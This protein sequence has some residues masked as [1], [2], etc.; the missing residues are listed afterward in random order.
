M[1]KYD[2][3]LDGIIN[4]RTKVENSLVEKKE[5]SMIVEKMMNTTKDSAEKMSLAKSFY[6]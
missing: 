5:Q 3:T 2:Q 6:V 1:S 4:F